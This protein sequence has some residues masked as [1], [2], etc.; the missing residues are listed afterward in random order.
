MYKK[1]IRHLA[2]AA[3]FCLNSV[4]AHLETL[5][6]DD[7]ALG[8]LDEKILFVS[9]GS[10]CAP[11]SLT[12]SCGLRKAAFPFDWNI[13]MD[14]EKLIEILD[15]GFLHFLNPNYLVPLSPTTLL[16]TYYRLE[17]V[18]DGNWDEEHYADFMPLLQSKYQRRIERFKQLNTYKGK[19]FFLRAAYIYSVEDPH[20]FY[21]CEE[22]I[23]I[24]EEYSLRLYKA[25]GELFP[26]LDFHLIVIN[27]HE[28]PCVRTEINLHD[29][30][31]MVRA[32]ALDE[33]VMI[34]AY[35]VF[36]A[37]LIVNN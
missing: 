2:I 7:V 36:F 1:R 17:F 4:E 5:G 26:D 34:E 19:V 35:R 3:I 23:E 25:L 16:N 8:S 22:N 37:D 21:H 31:T 29:R 12:R 13:S 24:T 20:R 33:E 10:Y 18:H 28:D 6:G 32:P 14:G 11:A 15:Q 30:L 27:N 9:L